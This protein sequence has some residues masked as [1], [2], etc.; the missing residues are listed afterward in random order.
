MT[1]STG[2]PRLNRL[3]LA[4]I[5][6]SCSVA[7]ADDWPQWRGPARDG[8]WRE[9]GVVERFKEPE[10]RPRW[11]APISSGYSGPTVAA[12]RVY[13]TDRVEEPKQIER[14]H[15]FD[16][17][18]GKKLW[19]HAYNCPYRNISFT[20]GPRASVTID[21]GRAYAMGSMGHLICFDAAKGKVLWKHD[22]NRE[23][24]V[25]MPI[26]GLSAAPLIEGDLVILHIGG[27]N[28]CLVAL[29]K[30][31]G[32][33]RWRALDDDASY[34]API[35]IEQAARHMLVCWTGQHVVG[36]DPPTGKLL[37][38]WPFTPLRGVV[39]GVATPV[40]EKGRLF[41]SSF[42]DGSLMLRLHED[43]PAV[44]QIW[45]RFGADEQHTDSLHSLIAT[46]YLKDNFV[47]GVDSYGELRCLDADTGD[48]VWETIEPIPLDYRFN[49]RVRRWFNIH[50]V[51]NHGKVWLF[52]ERGELIISRLSPQGY[53]EIS[54]AKLI[55]P[56][57]AQLNDRGGVCWSHPA[58]AYRHVFARNDEELIAVDLSAE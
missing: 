52:T 3:I 39:V 38:S 1:M 26:W 58:F 42:Y 34:S 7:R 49:P 56:T 32:K 30:A 37:W 10:L 21:D 57:H 36:L 40:V 43:K 41:V 35:I 17:R 8:V 4:V 54:R 15:C 18:T 25:R 5:A 29:D 27:E 6:A 55:Q 14:V 31:T 22:L 44:E 24:K 11:R 20:A 23:Y 28:A 47:Y 53:D 48:R 9:T 51:E 33:K 13:V 46:P 12:G 45:R 2:F 19:S 16:W 50:L